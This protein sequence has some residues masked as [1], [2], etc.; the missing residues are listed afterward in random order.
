MSAFFLHYGD[1]GVRHWCDRDRAAVMHLIANVLSEFGLSWQPEGADADVV[2]VEDYYHRRGGQ[3]WVVE[4]AS[5]VVG[6]IAF[7]PIQRGEAAVEIRKMYLHPRVRGQGLGTFLLHHLEVAIAAAG[8][9]K[10]WIE[11]ASIMTTAVH[12]YEKAGYQPATGVETQ[13]CDRV[14]VKDLVPHGMAS[15]ASA[16]C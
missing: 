14:Y 16:P 11:T 3:F 12:L 10:I 8:Y 15:M 2:H 7:Y 4:R 9:R 1:C 13:R 5:E 6:T